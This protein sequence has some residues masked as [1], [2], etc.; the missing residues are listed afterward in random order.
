MVVLKCSGCSGRYMAVFRLIYA[1][2]ILSQHIFLDSRSHCKSSR[3]AFCGLFN[4]NG[5]EHEMLFQAL[6]NWLSER[7]VFRAWS[8]GCDGYQRIV[9][10][11]IRIGWHQLPLAVLLVASQ[12]T[13][14][15]ISIH[16]HRDL[17]TRNFLSPFNT[18][19]YDTINFHATVLLSFFF[20]ILVYIVFNF[21]FLHRSL[22]KIYK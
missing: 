1:Y 14:C 16:I 10:E 6:N 12:K 21:T 17:S 15:V 4:L 9:A 7:L 20:C 2:M 18:I 13:V 8:T 19:F 5:P 11:Q 3:N 22:W